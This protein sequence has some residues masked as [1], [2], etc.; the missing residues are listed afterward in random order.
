LNWEAVGAIAEALGALAVLVTFVYLSIQV[1]DA[2][3]Q[4]QLSA[5]ESRTAR[6]L[7][8]SLIRV[9]DP[10]LA[11]I[12]VKVQQQDELTPEEVI[13]IESYWSAIFR[14]LEDLH[15]QMT[16]GALDDE[17]WQSNLAGIQ[18]MCEI[19]A[20]RTAWSRVRS[21]HRRSFVKLLDGVLTG[22]G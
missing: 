22:S 3:R 8:I 1:R 11:G 13:R 14:H 9:S 18:A 2:R 10:L 15:Y 12:I 21:Q 20:A 7:K 5:H 4:L 16:A 17:T 19:P 6:N